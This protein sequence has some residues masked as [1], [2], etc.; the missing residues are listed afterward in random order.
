MRTAERRI[1][2][3]GALVLYLAFVAYQSLAGGSPRACT[4]P[5]VD[6]GGGWH[7]SDVLANSVAYVP[8]GLLAGA[9]AASFGSRVAHAIAWLVLVLFSL[10]MELAQACLSGRVS[11]WIDWVTNSA[12]AAAG[13]AA[14]PV[15]AWLL[16]ALPAHVG[17]RRR[18]DA[19]VALMA[20][21]VVGVW[22]A[23][24]TVPWRFTFDVGTVRANLAFL[25]TVPSLQLWDVA[26]HG[27]AW[28]AVAGALR[29]LVHQ[30]GRASVALV[31]AIAVSL[32]AQ[33]LL[34]ARALSWS[35]LAGMA[36]GAFVALVLLVPAAAGRLALLVP[37]LAL[38]SVGAYELAP[39][40]APWGASAAFSW[41]P[42]IGR[43]NLFAALDFALYFCWFA[44]V[45]V[46]ALRW[47]GAHARMAF[48]CGTF[49]VLAM[50][51][52]E[53]M[54][55]SIPGRTADTSPALIVA[56]AFLVA[57]LLSA[58]SGDRLTARARST[59]HRPVARSVRRS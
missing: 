13:V 56:L 55:R 14:L 39:G 5:L 30:R 26:R 59:V 54:Q 51:A 57:W 38:V 18:P 46:F 32:L 48:V 6:S 29:A 28:M 10:S 8:A 53:A 35:E 23:S 58:R 24:T 20:W 36:L 21:L 15:A 37:V 34:E 40:R 17:W 27:F 9:L 25:R 47:R 1:A 31:L 33:A 44:F 7:G 52:M 45:L 16:R 19:P 22:L 42:L 41:W 11:S 12:G 43:G 4:T 2:L 3:S 49:A 50:L